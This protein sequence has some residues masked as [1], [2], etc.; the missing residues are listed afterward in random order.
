[1]LTPFFREFASLW[2]LDIC[3][4]HS[5]GDRLETWGETLDFDPKDCLAIE[6]TTKLAPDLFATPVSVDDDRACLVVGFHRTHLRPK[7]VFPR[8]TEILSELIQCVLDHRLEHATKEAVE[9]TVSTIAR[10]LSIHHNPGHLLSFLAEHLRQE[11]KADLLQIQMNE[12]PDSHGLTVTVSDDP[13]LEALARPLPSHPEINAHI[14]TGTHGCFEDYFSLADPDG[15]PI[16]IAQTIVWPLK[17]GEEAQGFLLLLR[18]REAASFSHHERELLTQLGSH[19]VAIYS[20]ARVEADR[21]NQFIR[22][23][24]DYHQLK[25]AHES[26]MMDLRDLEHQWDQQR[27]LNQKLTQVFQIIEVVRLFPRDFQFIAKTLDLLKSFAQ[28]DTSILCFNDIAHMLNIYQHKDR[29][30][31]ALMFSELDS[32]IYHDMMH[33]TQALVWDGKGA[34]PFHLP[35]GHPRVRDCVCIPIQRDDHHVGSLMVA[36]HGPGTYRDGIVRGLE[37]LTSFLSPDLET[38]FEASRERLESMAR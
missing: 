23:H 11:L 36:N 12:E 18:L 9:S 21:E 32:G 37:K 16:P 20:T 13:R 24:T 1:M 31:Q 38:A 27:H 17:N 15:D 35:S 7:R 28:A 5:R 30:V 29:P 14:K 26:M 25:E 6:K 22:F 34:R 2:C 33:T 10:V 3:W 4:L 8:F 19:L